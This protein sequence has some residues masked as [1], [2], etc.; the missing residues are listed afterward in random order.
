MRWIPFIIIWYFG[1]VIKTKKSL[2]L[3]KKIAKITHIYMYRF[4]V[5]AM[6]SGNAFNWR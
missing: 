4:F 1:F 6:C 3:Y 5:R 2:S